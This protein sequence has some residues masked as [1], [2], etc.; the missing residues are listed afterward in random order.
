MWH[1]LWLGYESWE[2]SVGL[3]V[4]DASLGTGRGAGQASTRRVYGRILTYVAEAVGQQ[5]VSF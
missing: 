1:Y 2:Q 4:A 3:P 5:L